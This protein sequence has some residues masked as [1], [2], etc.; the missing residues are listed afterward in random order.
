MKIWLSSLI[1][2]TNKT[3]W[4]T[5]AEASSDIQYCEYVLDHLNNTGLQNESHNFLS[6][7]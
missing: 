3:R 4:V 1:A 5:R 7:I 2:V 6:G